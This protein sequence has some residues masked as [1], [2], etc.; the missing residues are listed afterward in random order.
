MR[1]GIPEFSLETVTFL[2]D[3]TGIDVF[4][5]G[6][7]RE[8]EVI[9]GNRGANAARDASARAIECAPPDNAGSAVVFAVWHG[10]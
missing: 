8:P 5:E 3:T 4:E 6:A 10:A 2:P 7:L 9:A 1:L